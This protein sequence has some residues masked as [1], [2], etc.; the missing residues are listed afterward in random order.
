MYHYIVQPGFISLLI[1]HGLSRWRTF[2]HA[3]LEL[4][5]YWYRLDLNQHSPSLRSRYQLR[6][7]YR[8]NYFSTVKRAVRIFHFDINVK[9]TCERIKTYSSPSSSAG[10]HYSC[11][12]KNLIPAGT[13]P[14]TRLSALTGFEPVLSA[15]KAGVLPLHNRAMNG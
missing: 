1:T 14:Q 6:A 12:A 11:T 3:L 7:L 13:M 4:N 2:Q 5:L 10:T 15:S 9:D 8:H